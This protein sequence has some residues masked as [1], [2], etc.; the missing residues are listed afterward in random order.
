MTTT[1]PTL[2]EFMSLLE[3]ADADNP[4]DV[5]AVDAF[6]ICLLMTWEADEEEDAERLADMYD[7]LAEINQVL[8]NEER[9]EAMN[10][11][12]EWAKTDEW[13]TER[14]VAI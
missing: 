2:D 6:L 3:R 13:I 11:L 14:I 7:N 8:T 4:P 12:M 10:H 9:L 1:Y 5:G